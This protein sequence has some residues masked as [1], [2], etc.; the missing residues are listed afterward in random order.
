MRSVTTPPAGGLRASIMR[1]RSFLSRE[2]TRILPAK[3][4]IP[5]SGAWRARK[6]FSINPHR[7]NA[8]PA[9]EALPRALHSFNVSKDRNWATSFRDI[10]GAISFGLKIAPS[11]HGDLFVG[12]KRKGCRA[13]HCAFSRGCSHR[14]P[15]AKFVGT[16]SVC[17]AASQGGESPRLAES[18]LR[19]LPHLH[20]MDAASVHP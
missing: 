10:P 18:A 8:R 13:R 1:R 16:A 7:Q 14:I 19:E 17:H 20:C 4:V 5:R 11:R 3:G 6:F 12:V 2:R 15:A 9:T